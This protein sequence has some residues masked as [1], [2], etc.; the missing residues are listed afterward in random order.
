MSKGGGAKL[1]KVVLK[2]VKLVDVS[3][4]V[5]LSFKGRLEAESGDWREGGQYVS[6]GKNNVWVHTH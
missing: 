5:F 3:H 4:D 2:G 6:G 1:G